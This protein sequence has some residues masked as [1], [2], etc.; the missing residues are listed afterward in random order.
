MALVLAGHRG[1]LVRW[2]PLIVYRE[3]KSF[4]SDVAVCDE[5]LPPQRRCIKWLLWKLKY[6]NDTYV[7]LTF[8]IND[9]F[10]FSLNFNYISKMTRD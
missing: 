5:H 1:I 3:I 2:L 7:T 9:L 10:T 6:T 4:Q 8:I